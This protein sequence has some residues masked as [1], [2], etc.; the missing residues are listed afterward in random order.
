MVGDKVVVPPNYAHFTIN[1]SHKVLI[2]S[3]W[4]CTKSRS[5]YKFIKKRHGADYYFIKDKKSTKIMKNPNYKYHPKLITRRPHAYPE[6]DLKKGKP[7]Y[8]ACIE[9][10]SRF[11]FLEH[12][13]NYPW[14]G[15]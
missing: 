3:N 4:M 15:W 6:F 10:P 11:D 5:K 9:N 13:Q 2:M 7:M 12:P 1:P 8:L 14:K